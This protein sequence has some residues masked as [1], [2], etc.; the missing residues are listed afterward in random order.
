MGLKP[1]SYYKLATCVPIWQTDGRVEI[2]FFGNWLKQEG[3]FHCAGKTDLRKKRM[4][5]LLTI[6]DRRVG[7]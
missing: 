7:L 6:I 5:G 3:N 1:T 4:T 2:T